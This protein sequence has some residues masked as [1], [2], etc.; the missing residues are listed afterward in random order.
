MADDRPAVL[1]SPSSTQ[2]KVSRAVSGELRPSETGT[3][4]SRQFLKPTT[5]AARNGVRL[6]WIRRGQRINGG[7]TG[8]MALD[9]WPPLPFT[10]WP[11]RFQLLTPNDEGN[12]RAALESKLKKPFHALERIQFASLDA[13]SL[14]LP[15]AFP[16][17]SRLLLSVRDLVTL[18]LDMI[19]R[20]GWFSP[21]ALATGLRAMIRLKFTDIR[22]SLPSLPRTMKRTVFLFRSRCPPFS[23]R[24][25]IRHCRQPFTS[26]A[27]TEQLNIDTPQVTPDPEDKR[28]YA[29]WLDIFSH[30]GGAK[31]LDLNGTFLPVIVSA[32]G[33][34]ARGLGQG[35]LHVLSILHLGDPR[36]PEW[37]RAMTLCRGALGLSEPTWYIRLPPVSEDKG[38]YSMPRGGYRYPDR[39]AFRDHL[40]AYQ[41]YDLPGEL[42]GIARRGATPGRLV[43][44]GVSSASMA[45]ALRSHTHSGQPKRVT[46]FEAPAAL[47]RPHVVPISEVMSLWD[48]SAIRRS[49]SGKVNTI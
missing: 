32:V 25:S 26:L 18:R 19:P 38:Q 12:I 11:P 17:L 10:I 21:K 16:T 1:L 40:G 22:I 44:S 4:R 7:K 46:P 33:L 49:D 15:I 27:G 37:Q 43:A 47:S 5:R 13:S 30:L 3:L 14:A 28:E 20:A 6:M 31:K 36:E 42:A 8:R 34:S 24:I 23:H 39:C 35:V 48:P 41:S 29:Q 9:C 2:V 45:L